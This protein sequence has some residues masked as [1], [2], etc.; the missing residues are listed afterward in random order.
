MRVSHDR[1]NPRPPVDIRRRR[2]R[3][4]FERLARNLIKAEHP[5]A[6]A[7]RVKKGD[8][9]ID[10]YVGE[11]SDKAGIDVYQ[12][13]FFPLGLGQAQKAQIQKSFRTCMRSKKFT[14]KKWTLCLPIEMSSDEITWFES[15]KT[16]QGARAALIQGIWSAEKLEKLLY[17]DKNRGIKEAFFKEEHLKQIRELHDVLPKLVMSIERRLFSEEAGR[18][19][20]R[21]LDTLK[22][23]AENLDRYMRQVREGYAK[24]TKPRGYSL[25]VV[26][27]LTKA[28]LQDVGRAYIDSHKR[29]GHWE[30]VIRPSVIPD[31]KTIA[32]I[33]QCQEI[34][35]AC[36]VQT[37]HWSY[38]HLTGGRK[39]GRDWVGMVCL[40]KQLTEYWQM[41]QRLVFARF[42]P[43]SQRRH[44]CR[45][46]I[47]E[48]R[49]ALPWCRHST[50]NF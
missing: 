31:G 41:S 10:V 17:E 8:D 9:G 21:K 15:W 24:V 18:E 43:N 40:S 5:T 45:K 14:V 49:R 32:T 20:A 23:E 13:K 19:E 29:L 37:A 50:S 30:V 48:R 22:Q 27:Q 3:E 11:W 33:N 26:Q 16:R 38:P 4:Q 35:E 39:T 42:V 25:S 44:A 34:V 36:Q 47:A 2:A 28:G 1:Q 46:T 6:A 7:V 12:C